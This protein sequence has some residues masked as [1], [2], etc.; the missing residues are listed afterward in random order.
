MPIYCHVTERHTAH[1]F[2]KKSFQAKVLN[3]NYF[4]SMLTFEVVIHK[5]RSDTSKDE[6]S[7]NLYY[8]RLNMIFFCFL[9]KFPL[10]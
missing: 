6:I 10:L 3:E 4:L 1:K 9:E 8:K 5:L 2:K 7:L